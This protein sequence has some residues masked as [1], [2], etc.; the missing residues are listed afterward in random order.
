MVQAQEWYS[1]FLELVEDLKRLLST[2]LALP[3]AEANLCHRTGKA[4]ALWYSDK[5]QVNHPYQHPKRIAPV[6]LQHF[7]LPTSELKGWRDRTCS[8]IAANS[9]L[10]EYRQN[11]TCLILSF[12]KNHW[13]FPIKYKRNGLPSSYES[14]QPFLFHPCNTESYSLHFW[15]S[16]V[17]FSDVIILL[18]KWFLIM[19]SDLPLLGNGKMCR[20]DSKNPLT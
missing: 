5:G 10:A 1:F 18:K 2:T 12:F 17:P 16:I 19:S 14:L 6:L 3:R 4:I 15:V 8:L 20:R 11:F 13:N 7:D 9:E